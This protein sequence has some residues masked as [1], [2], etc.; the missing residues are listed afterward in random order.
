VNNG[1]EIDNENGYSGPASFKCVGQYGVSKVL[2]QRV[3]PAHRDAYTLSF[4]VATENLQPGPA[5]RVGVEVII[6][7]K[8]GSSETKWLSIL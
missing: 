1:W 7:Y 3:W 8:D 2:S 6:R 4:R 5:A